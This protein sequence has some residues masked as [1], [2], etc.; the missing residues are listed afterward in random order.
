MAVVTLQ[1]KPSHIH[2]T[3]EVGLD[4][5]AMTAAINYDLRLLFDIS[6]VFGVFFSL[7]FIFAKAERLWS[8]KRR[9]T[10]TVIE[11]CSILT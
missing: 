10:R 7:F 6:Y 3:I 9:E 8:R 1:L 11:C 4:C 5:D 2:H